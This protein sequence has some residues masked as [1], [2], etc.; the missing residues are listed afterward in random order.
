MGE[1]RGVRVREINEG[2]RGEGD[3]RQGRGGRDERAGLKT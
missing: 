2:V 1:M 3:Q